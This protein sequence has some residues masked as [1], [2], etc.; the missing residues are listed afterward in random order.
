MIKRVTWFAGGVAAGAAGAGYAK[1]KV[2]RAAQQ[3]QPRQVAASA[4]AAVKARS[5]DGV[6]AVREGR[7]AMKQHEAE[8][9][10]RR[11]GRLVSLS[12]HLGPDD[13]VYIDGQPVEPGRVI[14]MRPK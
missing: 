13:E 9:V 1:R 5:R 11:E 4:A 12:D 3:V 10:A 6:E 2:V 7:E 8:E 14:V